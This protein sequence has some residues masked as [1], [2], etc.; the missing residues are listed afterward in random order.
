MAHAHFHQI[1]DDLREP[2]SALREAIPD[3]MAGYHA[4]HNAAFA[5]GA[6]L[7]QDQGAHR[8]GHRHHPGVRRVH[9]RPRPRTWP[10]GAPARRR[11]PR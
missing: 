2:Y 3:V 10:V 9:R 6:L 1:Q 5:E 11:W 8:V 7:G 4:L